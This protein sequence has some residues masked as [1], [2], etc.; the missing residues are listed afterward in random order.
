MP[1]PIVHL[2]VQKELWRYL[3]EMRRPDLSKL[4]Q[5]SPCSPYTGF[6]SIGPD[7]LFFSMKEYGTDLAKLVNLFKDIY[8]M[9]EPFIEFYEKYIE[10]V[11]KK[12]DEA[13]GWV[14]EK[15]FHG[16]FQQL[17]D[18][19]NTTISAA[20]LKL[21]SIITDKVDFFYAVYP[22]VQLGEP[23]NEWYWFDT[24]HYRRT[25]TFC[26][27]MWKLAKDDQDL[28]R[29]CLGYAS[30]IGTD[31]VGHPY[32]NAI[33]GGP[34]RTHWHRH[35]LVEN[36]IDAYMCNYTANQDGKPFRECNLSSG[37]ER[38]SLDSISG[39]YLYK[40][41]Q[42]EDDKLPKKLGDMFLTA[43]NTT[44]KD[45]P[46]PRTLSFEDLDS[47]YRMWFLWF[48]KVTSAGTAVKP[49]RVDRPGDRTKDLIKDFYGGLPKFPGDMP[50]SG[51]GS[52][53]GRFSI[54]H[55]L[56]KLKKFLE[57]L[58]EVVKYIVDWTI[59]HMV[60]IVTLGYWEGVQM[61]KFLLNQIH[62]VIYEFYDNS[63]FAL[64][65]AGYIFPESTDLN[66]HPWGLSFVNTSYVHLTGGGVANFSKYPLRQENH[67]FWTPEHHLV[68]PETFPEQP[69]AEPAPMPF[70]GAFPEYFVY[71]AS[72]SLND[73]VGRLYDCMTPYG[74]HI[75]STHAID[76]MTWESGQLG[77]AIKCSADLIV[78]RMD[79]LPNFNLDGDR[80]YG[81]KTWRSDAS[82]HLGNA[83]PLDVTY[84]D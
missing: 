57:Y 42:F 55:L 7:F 9:L 18:T 80:G 3:Q 30:H 1:G 81:W 72:G 20:K 66:K 27:N 65:L 70:Y 35:K 58:A 29:Y 56:E 79:N 14:D 62:R 24:L 40:L 54:K 23:E 5:D 84:M 77:N 31:V 12:V 46:H 39:S 17:Q 63:R 82:G 52:G 13:A 73:E 47:T 19:V 44:F 37:E 53:R 8:D 38:Y 2:I 83:N 21:V 68:Y 22:K 26:S 49:K 43:L 50:G 10:P 25:G 48:K 45:T 28:M 71:K 16:L 6:G 75:Q 36:W 78:S 33:V 51:S 60:D 15:L 76:Q 69:Y 61:L 41:C 4:L 34:Y 32:V 64:V 74:E 67:A 11:E 59:R